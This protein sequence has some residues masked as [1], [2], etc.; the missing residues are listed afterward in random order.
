MIGSKLAAK[1]CGVSRNR[2][3]Q[4]ARVL[5][6]KELGVRR[7]GG[8]GVP[9]RLWSLSQISAMLMLPQL[10]RLGVNEEAAAKF[11]RSFAAGSDEHW[12]HNIL[13]GRRWVLIAGAG[14]APDVMPRE[15]A[16][17][18]VMKRAEQLADLGITP[19]IIDI[20]CSFL[21]LLAA[22]RAEVNQGATQSAE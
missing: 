3:H 12:E 17:L 16:E 2:F 20:G 8:V 19:A 5:K 6:L 13:T 22:V 7:G 9:E 14:I 4:L 18:A 21:E 15:S 1:L 10:V 11:C